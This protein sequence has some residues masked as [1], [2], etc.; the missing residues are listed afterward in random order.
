MRKKKVKLNF[1]EK[2][3]GIEKVFELKEKSFK[4]D[5]EWLKFT[6]F[7]QNNLPNWMRERE[8]IIVFVYIPSKKSQ[9]QELI[10]QWKVKGS[11]ELV[12]E[13]RIAPKF[14]NFSKINWLVEKNEKN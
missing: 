8:E 11:W 3:K 7:D 4:I 1:V 9:K 6:F 13:L 2:E 14:T 10:L 5:E 12:K